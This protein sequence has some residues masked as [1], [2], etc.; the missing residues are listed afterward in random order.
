MRVAVAVAVWDGWGCAQRVLPIGGFGR[1]HA[2][3]DHGSSPTGLRGNRMKKRDRSRTRSRSLRRHRNEPRHA[4]L[5]R[6]IRV[7]LRAQGLFLRRWNAGDA[8]D[9]GHDDQLAP[10]RDQTERPEREPV[11]R[12]ADPD[13]PL[14]E[15][16]L[17][18]DLS[19][20][21]R[22]IL[23]GAKR[24]NVGR[25]LVGGVIVEECAG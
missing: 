18:V 20:E 17:P 23:D 19:A 13:A 7:A 14:E 12:V 25:I 16:V 3:L 11:D 5:I 9:R 24:E 22:S 8:E 21:N 15:V 2:H 6:S 4:R 1:R 10:E